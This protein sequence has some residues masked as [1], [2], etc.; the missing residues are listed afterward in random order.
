MISLD[1]NVLVRYLVQD[2]A[3]QAKVAAAAIESAAGRGERL[4]LTA[5]T[6]C[7]LV[8]AGLLG[9]GVTKPLPVVILL[10]VPYLALLGKN[11]PVRVWLATASTTS[12]SACS[13]GAS[14][15]RPCTSRCWSTRR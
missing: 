2:D 8:W 3:A 7:E 14:T 15:R 5:I 13:T 9:A 12:R 10:L 1:T 4:R 6:L 11:V